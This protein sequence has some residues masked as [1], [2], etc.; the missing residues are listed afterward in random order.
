MIYR[1]HYFVDMLFATLLL[2]YGVIMGS[3]TSQSLYETSLN[4][5]SISSPTGTSSIALTT[6][7]TQ[8]LSSHGIDIERVSIPHTLNINGAHAPHDDEH[9]GWDRSS[10][11][12]IAKRPAAAIS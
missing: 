1:Y 5:S 9:D 8:P 3:Y 6:I 11:S 12:D 2:S 10:P 4:S 7:S